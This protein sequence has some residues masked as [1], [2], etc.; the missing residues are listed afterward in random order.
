[1][2]AEALEA[3][4][5]VELRDRWLNRPNGSSGLTSQFRAT[6]S[7]PFSAMRKGAT[8]LHHIATVAHGFRSSVCD[9]KAE[10]TDHPPEVVE[11]A[12]AHVVPELG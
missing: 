11:A 7:G 5:L 9:W 3:R 8:A 6:R 2:T 1:M 10:E 12:L 4:R